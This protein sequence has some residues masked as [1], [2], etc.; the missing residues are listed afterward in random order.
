MY[1]DLQT[2]QR[3]IRSPKAHGVL[4]TY[5]CYLLAVGLLLPVIHG[6]TVAAVEQHFYVLCCLVP[7]WVC[8]VPATR[9]VLCVKGFTNNSECRSVMQQRKV[10]LQL[11][12]F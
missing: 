10:T 8:A 9:S 4:L 1:P 6:D 5:G 3:C 2:F 11:C 12:G 7:Y